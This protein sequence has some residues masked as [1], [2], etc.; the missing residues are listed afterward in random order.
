MDGES[1]SGCAIVHTELIEDME[2]VIADGSFA[3]VQGFSNLAVA[4]TFGNEPEHFHFPLGE[5]R[6]TDM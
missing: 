3:Q 1:S 5:S 2:K 6:W 4:H